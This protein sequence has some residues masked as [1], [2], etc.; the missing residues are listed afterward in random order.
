MTLLRAFIA[1]EIPIS[2]QAA[3]HQQTIGL[4]KSV[5]PSLL[6]WVPSENLHLTLKFLGDVSTTNLQF[7]TQMLTRETEKQ[8]CFSVQFGGLGA[9]PNPRRPRV[10][11][12]GL[13]APE[14]LATLYRSLEAAAARL[15]Y[16]PEEKPFSPHLTI[17]RVKQTVSPSG[18]QRISS[19]LEATHIGPIG[20]VDVAAVHLM[21]SDLK[22]T[23]PVY[24][25]LFSAPLLETTQ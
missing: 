24:T 9:F 22:P 1:L 13:H 11:W 21:K 10:I 19:A 17:G 18:L 25:R 8:P 4:R 3:I 2:I 6:R 7:V 14:T 12:I 5:D 16:S 20:R 23:G 15:G